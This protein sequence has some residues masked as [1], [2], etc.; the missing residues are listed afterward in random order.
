MAGEPQS[1]TDFFGGGAAPATAAPSPASAP[2]A[3]QFF[4]LDQPQSGAAQDSI[5][6][7]AA[8][9]GSR[10][11]NAVGYGARN[12]WGSE[13]LGLSADTET[14][15]RRAGIFNDYQN[16]H[17]SMMRSFNEAI[18]RPA[19]TVPDAFMR[20]LNSV[21]M[22]A[23]TGL[24]QSSEELEGDEHTNVPG[25]VVAHYGQTGIVRHSL[26][27]I[28]GG[29]GEVL[30]SIPEGFLP[31]LGISHGAMGASE[32][33]ASERVLDASR[34]RSAGVVGEGE[35]GFYDA[36]PIAHGDVRARTDAAREAGMGTAPQPAAP[37]VDLHELA[38]RVDPD[39]FS[40]Y[41]AL[42]HERAAAHQEFTRLSSESREEWP[43]VT[44]A[45]R[46]LNELIGLEPDVPALSEHF[47][48]RLRAISA[49][50]PDAL[51]DK[52]ADAYGRL[53]DA[54]TQP[55]EAME[56][57]RQRMQEADFKMRDL[58]P[59]VS[60]AYRQAADMTPEPL[61]LNAEPEAAAKDVA[62]KVG[63]VEPGEPSAPGPQQVAAV[64]AS[65]HPETAFKAPNV[66]GDET[67]GTVKG[68]IQEGAAQVDASDAAPKADTSDVAP[69]KP[70]TIGG[71]LKEVEG[72]GELKARGLSQ[73][74][75][76]RAVEEG[77]TSTFGDLPEYRAIS[78]SEQA[79][80]AANLIN[81]D[82]ERAKGVAMGT[83]QAPK[84]LLPESV[85]V[86]VEKH[87]LAI[88][89]VDTLRQLGTES[90]LATSAT[91]MGQ[92]LRTL[93][94]RD[95]ASPVGAIQEV[96]AARE[97]TLKAKNID[98]D[99]EKAKVV[100]EAKTETRRAATVKHDAWQ[101]FLGSIKCDV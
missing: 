5:W 58:S 18:I 1:A 98:L 19:A 11:L 32:A 44:S 46:D 93:G 87:A 78:M 33:A 94:E 95:K 90:K 45:R 75:E 6:S 50:A 65:E 36:A 22:S 57:A 88:G 101:D 12:G 41:D 80:A 25:G 63:Q 71:N 2:T 20:G 10:V 85:F 49:S 60:E 52:V 96:Q 47:E 67:L 99:A 29:A 23:A 48:E 86:A 43:E 69:P 51:L 92:R 55:T 37:P 59:Q 74:V 39:T 91:T 4:G 53:D 61:P 83:R 34:A 40:Q 30:G 31:E 7:S 66:L 81:G 28:T 73:G 68:E 13:P 27:A 9:A 89:D 79:D 100:S 84:G 24:R 8:T 21:I 17:T 42:A 70:R 62:G 64:A 15:L 54:L 3:A 76:A 38:R 56:V 16:G 97:A 72:T 35:A 14:A 82:W 77:L 26:A